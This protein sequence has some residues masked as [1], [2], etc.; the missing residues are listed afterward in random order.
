MVD[1]GGVVVQCASTQFG[2][3]SLLLN[4]NALG[5]AL[6]AG[7][8]PVEG[9]VQGHFLEVQRVALEPIPPLLD[10]LIGDFGDL[11]D[12]LDASV[13]IVESSDFLSYF[14]VHLVAF[15]VSAALEFSQ[16]RSEML[17]A[18]CEFLHLFLLLQGPATWRV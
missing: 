5:F 10:C 7:K 9:R 8:G 18:L 4:D 15:Y 17:E 6:A 3:N 13:F 11:G 12:D 1:S 16:L 2:K 14:R